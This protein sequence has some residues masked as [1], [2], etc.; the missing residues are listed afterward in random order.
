MKVSHEVARREISFERDNTVHLII[1]K[2]LA[3]QRN[4]PKDRDRHFHD[5][6]DVE[7]QADYEAVVWERICRLKMTSHVLTEQEL[8][9]LEKVELVAYRMMRED[10]GHEM[11][12]AIAV[13]KLL[14][15]E[16][17]YCREF[18]DDDEYEQWYECRSPSKPLSTASLAGTSV[19]VEKTE[20]IIKRWSPNVTLPV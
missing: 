8:V 20:L 17:S 7:D 3:W 9:N 11:A 5:G 14:F 2:V 4:G 19:R 13:S 16:N 12:L 10:C 18:V 6:G 1:A 15:D